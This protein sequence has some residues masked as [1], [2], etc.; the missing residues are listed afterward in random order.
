M[1]ISTLVA[2][3]AYPLLSPETN[4]ALAKAPREIGAFAE[5]RAECEHWAGEEPY[6]KPRARE[7]ASAVAKLRCE[8]LEADERALRRRYAGQPRMLELLEAE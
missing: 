3:L 8:R 5:R 4:R 2:L 1:M 6:D 7:I